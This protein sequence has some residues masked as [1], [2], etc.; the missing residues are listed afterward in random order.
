[1]LPKSC[2]KDSSLYVTNHV[3]CSA[4]TVK[5]FLR[6]HLPFDLR[7]I[8]RMNL[9][10]MDCNSALGFRFGSQCLSLLFFLCNRLPSICFISHN[11]SNILSAHKT[12]K[13]IFSSGT[14]QGKAIESLIIR[15]ILNTSQAA[16]N[17]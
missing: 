4:N 17:M 16:C 2:W 13:A 3:V 10:S 6:G 11:W 5:L 1:M 15:Y 12:L 8:M 7:Q 9:I 14:S